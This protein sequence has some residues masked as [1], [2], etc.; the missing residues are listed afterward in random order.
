MRKIFALV[1]VLLLGG[2]LFFMDGLWGSWADRVLFGR[3]LK[4]GQAQ[5]LLAEGRL[6]S[7][8][9]LLK[10]F[11]LEGGGPGNLRALALFHLGNHSILRA[12]QGD[13][14]GAKDADFHYREALRNDPALFPAKA[15][16]EILIRASEGKKKS[17]EEP[18]SSDEGEERSMESEEDESQ[19]G[20]TVSPPFLGNTP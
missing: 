12:M 4:F 11:V 19:R 15:N 14:T 10:E 20:P 1:F 9:R 3:E 5:R 17:Q 6:D 7:N 18:D 8:E 13:P 16:L 2:S